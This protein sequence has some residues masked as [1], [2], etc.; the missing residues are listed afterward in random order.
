[1]TVK[2]KVVAGALALALPLI[3]LWEGFSPTPYL[4]I[5]GVVTNCY[6]NTINVQDRSYSEKECRAILETDVGKR[7][8][9]IYKDVPDIPIP[10]LA[11]GT[12]LFYNA[13]MG[14]Y[15]SSTF[16]RLAKQGNWEATCNQ[17]PRWVYVT[18]NGRKVKSNGLINRRKEELAV[19]L[20][21]SKT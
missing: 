9:A 3:V 10:V 11:A 14:A 19:C 1:M 18:K 21:Y 6:G 4:D 16:R 17:I 7:M 12:S 20:T 13:G 15:Y 2:N 8:E 5:A